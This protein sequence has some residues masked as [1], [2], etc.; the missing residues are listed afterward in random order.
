MADQFPSC[1]IELPAVRRVD[2]EN[3]SHIE[4]PLDRSWPESMKLAW[5]AAV[6]AAESGLP[7]RLWSHA[8]DN[9]ADQYGIGV[10]RYG[11]ASYDFH[12]AWT[13]L[14]GISAGARAAGGESRG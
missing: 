11:M 9:R 7:I 14:T 8:G 13:L 6:V 3:G 4:P 10:G 2:T 1:D 12:S 5:K